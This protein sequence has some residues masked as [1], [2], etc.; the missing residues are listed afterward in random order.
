[1]LAMKPSLTMADYECGVMLATSGRF[2]E[3]LPHVLAYVREHPEN[4]TS[5]GNLGAV[6]AS[7]HRPE[8]GLAEYQTALKIQ[9]SDAQTQKN[10]ANLY[11][12]M[13]ERPEPAVAQ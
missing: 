12:E 5:H 1:M 11:R 10:L 13:G 3:A 9:P 6:Y 8:E 2:E 7:L 4:G